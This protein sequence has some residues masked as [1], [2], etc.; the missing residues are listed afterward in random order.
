MIGLK[1]AFNSKLRS[2]VIALSIELHLGIQV[3]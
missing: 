2:I 1:D 3:S